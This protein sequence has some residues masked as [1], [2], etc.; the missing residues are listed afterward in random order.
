MI[1]L[2]ALLG[3][4][5]GFVVTINTTGAKVIG[6]TVVGATLTGAAVVGEIVLIGIAVVGASVIGVDIVGDCGHIL[7]ITNVSAHLIKRNKVTS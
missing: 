6:A 5:V 4:K 2:T 3:D 7:Y 1:A